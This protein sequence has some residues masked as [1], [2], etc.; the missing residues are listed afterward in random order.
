MRVAVQQE[1]VAD[2]LREEVEQCAS[3]R[4]E[5][6]ADD[7]RIDLLRKQLV[8]LLDQYGH[9]GYELDQSLGQKD[10]RESG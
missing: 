3:L 5:S 2:L 8:Q 10:L 7:V 1:L 4:S 9:F 6:A